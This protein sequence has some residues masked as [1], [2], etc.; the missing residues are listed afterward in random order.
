MKIKDLGE[1]ALINRIAKKIRTDRSVVK[2]IGDDAAVIK[3]TDSKYLLFTC[4]ML[5]EDVHFRR[6]R[7]TPLEIG[8]KALARN[9]SDIAAMGGVP[10]YAVISIGLNAGLS[11]LTVDGI[12][13]GI[14]QL[15]REFRINIVGGD[16]VKSAK[17]VIDVSLIGEVEKKN[18]VL[19]SGARPGELIFVTGSIGASQK[20]K[21]LN[22][23]PRLEVARGLV[24]K[25]KLSSMIDVSDGLFI[26]LKRILDASSS[27]ARIYQ[28]L[29]PLS[30]G[31]SS[32]EKAVMEGEDFEL[33]FTMS[34]K[35]ALKAS[36]VKLKTP[37]SLI[38]SIIDKKLGFGLVDDNGAE[39]EIKTKGFLHF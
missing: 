30:K 26:D 8:R 28:K 22:F 4:D 36:R 3:W 18:L 34:P 25:F 9:I 2:G 15:A 12:L 6:S 32:F 35:E 20:A 16:T 17:L 24:K 21:H 10:R 13:K 27:G 5:V 1:I 7:A 29:V 37:V 38:G 31:A 23:T 39:K 33:L 11:V 14:T 19:R